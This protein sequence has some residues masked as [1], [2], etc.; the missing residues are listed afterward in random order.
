MMQRS[1]I[2]LLGDQ[3]VMRVIGSLV[4]SS[5]PLHTRSLSARNSL[6]PAGVSDIIRRLKQAGLLKQSK[7]KNAKCFTLDIKRAEI[8]CLK[9]FFA[10]YQIACLEARAAVLSRTALAKLSWMDE[11]YIFYKRLKRSQQ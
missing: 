7:R 10:A 5:K 4:K 3:A 2:K 6:S 8:E 1:L 11:S 9:S